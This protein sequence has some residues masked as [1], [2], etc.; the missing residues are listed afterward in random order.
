MKAQELGDLR[1][2]RGDLERRVHDLE[3][4]MRAAVSPSWKAGE[5]DCA[6]VVSVRARSAWVRHPS[7][8]TFSMQYRVATVSSAVGCRIL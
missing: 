3:L 8:A 7:R 4:M 6:M 2:R 1:A 5:P